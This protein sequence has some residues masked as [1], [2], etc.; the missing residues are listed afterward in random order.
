MATASP[1]TE[2]M[3]NV[4]S[5]V[6]LTQLLLEE[7]CRK[8]VSV[9][10][11]HLQTIRTHQKLQEFSHAQGEYSLFKS[12]YDYFP[13]LFLYSSSFLFFPSVRTTANPI[14]ALKRIRCPSDDHHRRMPSSF[15]CRVST[16]TTSFCLWGTVSPKERGYSWASLSNRSTITK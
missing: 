9:A 5:L 11:F 7:T 16:S 1:F 10:L 8:H 15:F 6:F 12:N 14:H 13:L 3:T 2:L 4:L